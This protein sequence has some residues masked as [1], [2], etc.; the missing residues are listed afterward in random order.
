MPEDEFMVSQT[1]SEMIHNEK[2]KRFIGDQL[3]VSIG[4]NQYKKTE[5]GL[6]NCEDDAQLVYSTFKES[7]CL[8]L[9]PQSKLILSSDDNSTTK[10]EI[11]KALTQILKNV[12]KE[13]NIVV[14]FSGHGC[15]INNE[16]FFIVTDSNESSESMISL[17]ELLEQLNNA[18][19]GEHGNITV[20]I[21]ACRLKYD[22]T[23]NL[24]DK[25]DKYIIDFLS[26]RK[27]T[28]II[29][30]CSIG[31]YSLNF[32]NKKAIS[33]FTSFLLDALNGYCE[34]LDDGHLT[35][36]SMFKYIEQESFKA[37][38]SNS[39]I[40]QHPIIWFDGNDIVYGYFEE[41]QQKI[42]PP[43]HFFFE[44]EYYVREAMRDLERAMGRI[45]D[46]YGIAPYEEEDG[47]SITYSLRVCK[48]FFSDTYD[49]F[50][51]QFP[52]LEKLIVELYFYFNKL[53][54][55]PQLRTPLATQQKFI[56]YYQEHLPLLIQLSR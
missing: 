23:K 11:L 32:Y 13:T 33:V 53:K 10:V 24:N 1:K 40:N 21:D 5:D 46:N 29:Y 6:E 50:Q 44:F 2:R 18:N 45:A 30:S 49:D 19:N 20:L 31:E 47:Y 28:G 8:V 16:F 27:G 12:Q 51:D 9:S 7:Q 56:N 3:L 55:Q 15:M 52:S 34:A 38:R 37:S 43:S 17:I 48:E 4:I 54:E 39:Q 36:H 22:I 25:S 41:K 14:F 42:E 26:R 35:F